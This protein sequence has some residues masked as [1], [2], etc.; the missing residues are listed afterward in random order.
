[1]AGRRHDLIAVSLAD[2][3]ET[4]LPRVGLVNLRDPETGE[5]RLL[6]TSDPRERRAYL[7]AWAAHA[8]SLE[9]FCLGNGIDLLHIVAGED[10]VRPISRF[11]L[12]RERRL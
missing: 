9:R 5:G 3:L 11:F 12:T 2:P 4:H 6:D 1:V 8:S 7:A 10:Y